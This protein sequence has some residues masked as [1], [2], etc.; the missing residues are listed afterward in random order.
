MSLLKALLD[1]AVDSREPV[2]V[3]T[4]DRIEFLQVRYHY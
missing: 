1:E 3:V 4:R 2:N